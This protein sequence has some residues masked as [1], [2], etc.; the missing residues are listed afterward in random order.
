MSEADPPKPPVGY[1]SPPIA[2]QFRKGVSGNPQGRPRRAKPKSVSQ[3]LEFGAQPANAM[4]MDEAYRMVSIREGDQVIQLPAIKAVF[5]AMSVSA[6]KGNRHAQ[7]L[8]AELVRGIEESDRKSRMDLFE[9][10][11]EYKVDGEKVIADAKARNLLPPEMIPH[12]EDIIIDLK[13]STASVCG[14]WTK[15]EKETWDRQLECLGELQEDVSRHAQK[16]RKARNPEK[17]AKLLDLWK[18]YQKLFDRINDNL[19]KRYRRSLIDRNWEPDATRAGSLQKVK[20][21]GE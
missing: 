14:P 3:S 9:T 12:P 7:Q 13:N 16:F 20:W 2:H 1:G 5:R 10:M 6:M 18:F 4:L 11:V 21:P 19:P 17:K 8:I 15:E